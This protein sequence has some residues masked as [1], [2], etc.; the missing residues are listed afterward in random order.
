MS[1]PAMLQIPSKTLLGPGQ[2][3]NLLVTFG[4]IPAFT[5][6]PS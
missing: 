2:D 1:Y 4:L 3:T 6:G 5:K